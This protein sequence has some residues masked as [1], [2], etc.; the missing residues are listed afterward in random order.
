M[1][2]NLTKAITHKF[3][4]DTDG[5]ADHFP[6][7]LSA[8][9]NADPDAIHDYETIQRSPSE[10][11]EE[12]GF[13]EGSMPKS[14][15]KS[16]DTGRKYLVKAYHSSPIED[17]FLQVGDGFVESLA[18]SLYKAGN[19]HHLLHKTHVSMGKDKYGDRVPLLVVHMAPHAVDAKAVAGHLTDAELHAMH[20]DKMKVEAMDYILG[21]IDRHAANTMFHI[22]PNSGRPTGV[23]AI[24]NG[25]MAFSWL[26]MPFES[27]GFEAAGFDKAHN[28]IHADGVLKWWR[29]RSPFIRLAFHQ[30][31]PQ[32]ADDALRDEITKNFD[33]RCAHMD[34]IAE[35][36]E[37]N[38]RLKL[39]V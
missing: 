39:T 23:L 10:R 6:H 11:H 36:F 31:I 19:I 8:D 37:N 2:S 28:Q 25:G 29:E 33:M 7:V 16:K 30:Q 35:H 15:Y 14:L 5:P 4:A 38:G 27:R 20:P 26:H 3:P 32:M 17:D 12:L 34:R 13:F 18:S 22:D 9:S 24:D 21:N 1:S